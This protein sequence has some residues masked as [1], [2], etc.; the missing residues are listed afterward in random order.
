M[1]HEVRDSKQG[2][3]LWRGFDKWMTGLPTSKQVEVLRLHM[4]DIYKWIHTQQ[5]IA[6][7]D[8]PALRRGEFFSHRFSFPS[9]CTPA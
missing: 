2:E 7:T 8:K 9:L 4:V 6:A 3:N 1:D 5:L